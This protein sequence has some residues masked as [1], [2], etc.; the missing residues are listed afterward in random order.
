MKRIALVLAG[1]AFVA[2]TASAYVQAGHLSATHPRA[3]EKVTPP[4]G[5]NQS[6]GQLP[7]MIDTDPVRGLYSPVRGAEPGS[8]PT[9]P[10]PEPGTMALA[11]MGLVALGA[12]V[13]RRR[14]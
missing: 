1:L 12:A 13:R 2:G 7:G 3:T 8:G 10:V 6:P 11:S 9:N 4:P 5:S 14:G